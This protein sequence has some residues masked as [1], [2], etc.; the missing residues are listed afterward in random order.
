MPHTPHE[1][2]GLPAAR[3]E[4][5]GLV[6]DRLER[7][8][9]VF[10]REI[11]AGK[12][13]G[14]SLLIARRGRIGFLKTLGALKPGGPALPPDAIFR[15]YSMTKPITSVAVMR[16]LEDGRLL[17]NDPV[18]KYIPAFAD[19]Q[20]GVERGD[21]LELVAPKRPPT[22]QDLLR[23][24]S[25]LT[26]G[27][28]GASVV[29]KLTLE[30]RTGDLGRTNAEAA[31]AIAAL[32]LMHQ[33]GEAW[34]YSVSTDILGRIVEVIEGAPL[35][36]VFRE[37]IFSPLGMKDTDFYTPAEKLDRRA[38][39]FDWKGMLAASTSPPRLEYGG[40]GLFST[41]GDYA[42]FVAMLHNG[43]ALHG[44]R[45]LSPATLRFMTSDH[46]EPRV[47]K[48]HFLLMPGYGFGLGFAVRNAPGLAPTAGG[49]GEY[50]WG[51]IAGTA[52]FVSPADDLYAIMMVQA[53]EYREYL[54]LLFRTQVYAALE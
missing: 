36:E 22:V 39:A 27:F 41:L 15:I 44:R 45:L 24:T 35:G 52:F 4:D 16:L 11:A 3:P 10:E 48:D 19:V 53:P 9:M 23:H 38:E 47:R 29:Q 25:G 8:A 50:N 40:G 7:L 30:A 5:V 18:S 6:S 17:L 32:P 51:G 31:E 1:F 43:G 33:P 34:E 46:L 12:A 21:R 2:A 54:R 20:V 28:T 13:P 42:R 26:Y 14:V 37:R 49:V